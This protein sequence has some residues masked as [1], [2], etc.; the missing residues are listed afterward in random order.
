MIDFTL[1]KS[2]QAARDYAHQVALEEM[3]PISLECDRTEQIPESFFWNMQ[4]RFRA[5]SAAQARIQAQEGEE[6]AEVRQRVQAPGR[7]AGLGQGQPALQQR[8]RRR[9]Q[10]VGSAGG[11]GQQ[12][13]DPAGGVA[14]RCRLPDAGV[15]IDDPDHGCGG[16]DR[17]PF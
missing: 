4:K 5:G 15:R 13:Q 12:K 11:C 8:T 9:E 1:S 17:D 16:M 10:K 14:S 7:S 3:R 2:Q 6:R